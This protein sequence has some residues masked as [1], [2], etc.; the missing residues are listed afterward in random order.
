MNP[1]HVI[2]HGGFNKF[3]FGSYCSP[4]CPTQVSNHEYILTWSKKEFSLPN[5]NGHKSD[6]KPEDFKKWILSSWNV[7]PDK[8]PNKLHHPASF[9]DETDSNASKS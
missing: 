9:P 1:R 6:I 7:L 3:K 5:Q 4:S 8:I 2:S